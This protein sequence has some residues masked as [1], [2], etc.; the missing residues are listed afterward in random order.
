MLDCLDH[1]VDQFRAVVDGLQNN[2]F[3]KRRL[4]PVQRLL[5]VAGHLPAVLTHEHEAQTQNGLAFSLVGDR[6]PA[7]LVPDG[8]LRHVSDQ[9]RHSLVG[10]KNDVGDL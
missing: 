9:N 8:H 6:A 1:L 5:K 2:V 7:Q 4:H 10:G 3:G